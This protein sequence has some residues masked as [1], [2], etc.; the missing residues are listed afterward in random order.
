VV[1]LELVQ[2]LA[3]LVEGVAAQ[4]V[5]HPPSIPSVG[6]HARVL[7]HLEM[8]REPGLC[9]IER[10]SQLADAALTVLE[11][12]H[13]LEPGRIRQGVKQVENPRG[14]K[15]DSHIQH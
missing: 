14:S 5:I 12:A 8:E 7:Q 3:Q 13:D 15:G 6:N 11:L 9:G 2:H 1:R 4:L 10:V